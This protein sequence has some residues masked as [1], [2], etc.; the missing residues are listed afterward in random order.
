[1]L[2]NEMPSLQMEVCAGCQRPIE[3]R[4]LLKVQN[5]YWHETCMIC[6][7]CRLPL[8]GSCFM[9]DSALYCRADYE[10]L[11]RGKCSG[12]GYCISAQELVMK[13]NGNVYHMNCFR[14]VEC[15]HI[16]QKGDQY[17][18]K[19]GQLFC[20]FDFDKEF[21]VLSY[22]PKV[23]DDSDSYEDFDGDLDRAAK[24]PRTILNTQQRRK[25]KAA[26]ELNPKPCR[27]VR[28]Q[29]ASETGLTVRVV[30]VW[31]QNQ[32]AKVK[33]MSRRGSDDSIGKERK[34]RGR[35]LDDDKDPSLYQDMDEQSLRMAS[36]NEGSLYSNV[37]LSN[38]MFMD[39]Q[40][41]EDSAESPEQN[42]SES[43]GPD[44]NKSRCPTNHINKLY[45][46][47][48]SYFCAE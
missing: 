46:M 15:G 34:R 40:T 11:F 36:D 20:R 39:V 6:A 17:V 27:K 30:Q 16:L 41:S 47:Q 26:F 4:Y 2:K 9:R 31:F 18:L 3:D 7:I 43:L 22:S 48:N 33:K 21:S 37:D 1:M 28:E 14:C 42:I 10:K 32:R 24:R 45:S 29:L 12:C 38:N 19:D 35:H 23:E 25:F 5:N 44:L 8:Q 13:A